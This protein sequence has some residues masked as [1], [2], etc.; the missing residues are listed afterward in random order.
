MLTQ[1]NLA[2]Y[3]TQMPNISGLDRDVSEQKVEEAFVDAVVERDDVR[4]H[5]YRTFDDTVWRP[6]PL[7]LLS[8]ASLLSC[9]FKPRYTLIP[10]PHP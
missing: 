10:T 3:L 8:F 7:R 9:L 6:Y 4:F 2:Y 1:N 5:G